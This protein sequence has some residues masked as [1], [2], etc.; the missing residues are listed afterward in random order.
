M[1][2]ILLTIILT[3]S[4]TFV[5]SQSEQK[6]SKKRQKAELKAEQTRQI[7]KLIDSKN[8]TFKAEMVTPRNMKT[9]NLTTD[10]GL[11]I[12]EDS[13]FS[14]LP[15]F[16]NNYIRDFT[17]FKNSPLGFAQPINKYSRT[18]TKKGYKIEIK[19]I[20]NEEYINMVLHISKTGYTSLSAS[21]LD[22]Q[23]ITFD[24]EILIP[25]P[26]EEEENPVQ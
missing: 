8:Y 2:I 15:Y 9:M 12:K 22:R 20:N 11:Q 25:V 5:F 26:V 13:I 10:F 19:V 1:K 4:I 6:K 7:R 14:Y 3:F 16:G 17:S 23:S 24:G 21:F 18:Y